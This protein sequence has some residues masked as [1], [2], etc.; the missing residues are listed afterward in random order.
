MRSA[1]H[2]PH[3]VLVEGNQVSQSDPAGREFR[4]VDLASSGID[5]TIEDNSFGGGAGQIG[6]EMTYSAAAGQF[7]GIN[8]PEVIL[9]ESS[10]GVLFEGRP[11]AISADGQL[12][13]L[14]DL[15]DQAFPIDT[16]PGMVV[17]ILEGVNAD[18]TANMSLAGTVVSGRAAGQPLQRQHPRAAHGRPA[19]RHAARRLLR[20]RDHRRLR[21]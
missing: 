12:L 19:A 13:V 7:F 14:S 15:R 2:S 1:L 5:N 9:A 11:S 20:D 17:S 10:Y 16:G 18:G 21:Q 4:L 8:S 3:D 6:N